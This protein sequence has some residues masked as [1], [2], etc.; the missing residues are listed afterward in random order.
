[1]SFKQFND[2]ISFRM[3]DEI[4]KS[5]QS[6]INQ[7]IKN[8]NKNSRDHVYPTKS[9]MKLRDTIHVTSTFKSL[10]NLR[11]ENCTLD[12]FMMGYKILVLRFCSIA[13]VL[14]WPIL[15]ENKRTHYCPYQNGY[16]LRQNPI[17]V[18]ENHIFYL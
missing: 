16:S 18:I 14:M 17:R 11:F 13:R 15:G 4:L 8:N 1:M 3:M 6:I 5:V 2:Y 7:R 10:I 9:K 12:L